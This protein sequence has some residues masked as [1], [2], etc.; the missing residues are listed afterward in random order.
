MF[1]LGGAAWVWDEDDN[2]LVVLHTAVCG[3]EVVGM[4]LQ[5]GPNWLYPHWRNRLRR[6]KSRNPVPFLSMET[7]WNSLLQ[8]AIQFASRKV[9]RDI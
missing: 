2:G 4:T 9:N 8:F 6:K 5:R 1:D 3:L 7:A